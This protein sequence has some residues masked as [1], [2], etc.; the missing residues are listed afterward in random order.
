MLHVVVFN[1]IV[2]YYLIKEGAESVN[3]IGDTRQDIYQKVAD[4]VNYYLEVGDYPKEYYLKILK[5][6]R[7]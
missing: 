3:V 6:Q 7:G 1:F 2:G 5:V 4:K